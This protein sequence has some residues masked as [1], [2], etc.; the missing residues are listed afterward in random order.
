MS[1]RSMQRA[2]AR[3]S[4]RRSI[5]QRAALGAAAA[6]GAGAIAASG[7]Q[8]ADF[9][10]TNTAD[11]GAGSLRQ[12]IDDANA[13]IGADTITFSGAGASG[14]IE[15]TTSLAITDPVTITGPGATAL[16]VD[17][18]TSGSVFEISG[19]PSAGLPVT[20]SGLKI[21][22]GDASVGGGIYNGTGA[23]FASDLTVS[24]AVVSNNKTDD[25]GGGIYVDGGT[26]TVRNSSIS[27]NFNGDGNGNDYGGG[28]YV[29]DTPGL[30]P[31]EVLI[32][33][34]KVNDNFSYGDGGGAYFEAV[35]NDVVIERSTVSGNRSKEDAG[36]MSFCNGDGTSNTVRI[37]SSTFS[38]NSAAYG[39]G[40]IWLLCVSEAKEITN[41]TFT[42]NSAGE[43]GGGVYDDSSNP[44]TIR[45]TTIVDNEANEYGGGIYTNGGSQAPITISSSIVSGNIAGEGN[46]LGNSGNEQF[47]IG[48]SLIGSPEGITAPAIVQAPAGTNKIGIDPQ[49]GPLQD[50]GG[51]TQT[52]V[53]AITSPAIDA[54]VAN[55]LTADQR[56]LNRKVIQP[57]VPLSAG[58]DGTDIGAT[59]L[60]LV[61]PPDTKVDG[62]KVS[63]KKTQKQK[64]K[65]VVI[66]VKAEAAEAVTIDAKGSIKL[67]KKKIALKKLSKKAAAGKRLTL[68]LKPKQKSASA[69]VL[70]ALAN[71]GKAKAAVTVKFTD[72]AGNTDSKKANV[73]LK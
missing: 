60:A 39:A 54:G 35:D 9:S 67:G 34:S 2:H 27:R 41:S 24:D 63:A 48:N 21:V 57:T 44:L 69:K 14:R 40:G 62:A 16:T 70:D 26:L 53:P 6:L 58:S 31:V 56:G 38:D 12:A 25:Y 59:E 73:K 28:I 61:S 68:K 30:A 22:N 66:A 11:S 15:S 72:D 49:L 52:R 45:N 37:D 47:T 51:P 65:K 19:L 32:T 43:D 17:G 4:K 29:K 7:A 36:G 55:G 64:G 8:A 71:G 1:A 5:T 42:G 18:N 3:A 50:N 13:A 33:D 10:V 20:I 23:N 46:D